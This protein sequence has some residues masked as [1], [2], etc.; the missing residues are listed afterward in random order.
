MEGYV[1]L[2]KDYPEIDLGYKEEK[3]KEFINRLD[4]PKRYVRG[5]KNRILFELTK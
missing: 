4:K 1:E 3:I 2:K 5:N